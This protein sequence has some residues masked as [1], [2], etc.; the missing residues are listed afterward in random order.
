MGTKWDLG[1]AVNFTAAFFNLEKTDAKTTDLAGAITLLGDQRVNGVEFTV[2]GTILPRLNAYGGVAF[3]DGDVLKSATPSE[4]GVTLPYVPKATL[5]LWSTYELPMRLTVG[6]GVNYKS[7]NFFNQT[8]TFNFV[9]GG[10]VAQPKYA[11]NAAVI[12]ALTEYWEFNAM[13]SYPV[14]KHLSLQVNLNNIGNAKYADK[15]YD[16][17]FMPG[18]TRQILFSPVFSF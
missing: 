16:R 5:N 2:A 14:N 7:G 11:T 1:E 3:M 18:P 6:G 13:A 8:G 4:E 17:H 10:L 12:Q 9:A 15:A